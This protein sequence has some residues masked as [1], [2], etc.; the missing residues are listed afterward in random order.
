[1][2]EIERTAKDIKRTG[3]AFMVVAV[4]LGLGLLFNANQ[5]RNL[6][7]ESREQIRQSQIEGCERSND[8]SREVNRRIQTERVALDASVVVAGLS[9]EAFRRLEVPPTPEAKRLFRLRSDD[10]RRMRD[11]L[12]FLP[13]TDCESAYPPLK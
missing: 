5:T 1:M 8:R 10:I 4:L 6:S 7:V 13:P 3:R 2:S 12:Q 9:A 11:N